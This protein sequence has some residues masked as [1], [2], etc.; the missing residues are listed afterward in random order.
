MKR[1][2]NHI[3]TLLDLAF[4]RTLKSLGSYFAIALGVLVATITICS[5]VVYSESVNVSVLRSRLEEAHANA[6]YDLIIQGTSRVIDQQRYQELSDA[7]L[8]QVQGPIGL[9]VTRIGRHTWSKSMLVIPPGVDPTGDRE[10]LKRTRFEYYS[11]IEQAIEIIEGGLPKPVTDAQ[12]VVEAMATETLAKALGLKVGDIFEVEDFK[13]AGESVRVKTKLVAIF[14]LREEKAGMFYAPQFLDQALTIPEESFLTSVAIAVVPVDAETTWVINY[15]SSSVN[16]TNVDQVLAGLGV[17]EFRLKKELSSLQLLTNL[18]GVLKE[19]KHGTFVLTALLIVLGAPVI[20]IALYYIFM[21][22]EM[23]VEYQRGEIAVLKSRGSNTGQVL[24]MFLVQGLLV[25]L[26]VTLLA[27]LLAIPVARLIGRSETFMVF[28]N[29]RLLSV[30]LRPVFFGYA[31]LVGLLALA[32]IFIPTVQATRQTIVSYRRES[33]RSSRGFVLHKFYLDVVLLLLGVLGFR[34]LNSNATIITRNAT[35]GLEF[36]PLLLITPI[37]LAAGA[38]FLALRFIPY[39]F[40]LLARLDELVEHIA[41]L[42]AFRQIARTT[43]RYS[44]LILILTFTLALGLFTATV[45]SA[46]DRNYLDQA[47]YAVG[48]DLM[49]H[50]FDYKTVTWKVR[51]VAE[52]AEIPGVLSVT[53]LARINLVGRQAQIIAQGKLLAINPDTFAEIAWYREDFTPL[54]PEILSTLRSNEK[55]VLADPRFVQKNR[56]EI[57]DTFDIDVDGNRV[58]FVLVGTIGDYFPTLYPADGDRMVARLDYLQ[59]AIN[60]VPSEVWL[61]TRPLQHERVIEALKRSATENLV[62][63]QD[64]HQLSGV[65]KDDPLRTGLFGALSLGFVASS[66]LSI[67]GF[68]LY[69][70]ISIQSRSL[71]FGVLRATGL[72]VRQLIGSLSTEQ[73]S[74]IGIGLLLGTFLGGGAGWLFTRFLQVSIIAKESIPPFMIKVP[75]LTILELYVILLFIFLVALLLSVYLLKKMRVSAVL[76]LGEQ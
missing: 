30:T 39:L 76:R 1:I 65:R 59:K 4:H 36:D 23:L 68:L 62:V 70:Y 75:W 7:I 9:P 19:Y 49:T 51:T 27:P 29:P 3:T 38:A 42:F 12:D 28:S 72:S 22:A 48:A 2:L 24:G 16:I 32:A 26:P 45:S 66:V 74:L 8:A 47:M 13:G 41:S 69:A 63:V 46:F 34:R 60:T 15:D 31:G 35:G 54:L 57:G 43:S 55:G 18:D 37:V 21:S 71:Q 14:R 53:P 56:L 73:L 40:R 6:V 17:L 58:D 33:A 11:D 20:A 44:G 50:E 52:Y 61:K 64:G 5:M 67:M 10:T 25:V